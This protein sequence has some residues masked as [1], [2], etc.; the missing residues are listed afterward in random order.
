MPSALRQLPPE[1][2][3]C[4]A[5][6]DKAMTRLEVP[7]HPATNAP[8]LGNFASCAVIC[9]A[10]P[11]RLGTLLTSALPRQ[12]RPGAHVC[13]TVQLP[14]EGGRGAKGE[15]AIVRLAERLRAAG[16]RDVAYQWLLSNGPSERTLCCVWGGAA[17]Y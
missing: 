9:G 16:F 14:R 11:E 7:A 17:G 8:S 2:C 5:A 12:L 15:A 10:D 4:I 3:A 1:Q 6:A 13:A